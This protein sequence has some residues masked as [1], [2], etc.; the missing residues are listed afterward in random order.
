VGVLLLGPPRGREEYTS[1]E[2]QVLSESGEVFALMLE[3]ARITDRT[4]EQDKVRRDL[5]TAAE[6]QRRLLPPQAVL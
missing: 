6:V 1:A 3:N 2:Q 4:V 5:A